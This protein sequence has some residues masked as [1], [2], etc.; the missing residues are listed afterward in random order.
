MKHALCTLCT[1]IIHTR[2]VIISHLQTRFGPQAKGKGGGKAHS[3]NPSVHIYPLHVQANILEKKK[4]KKKW[5]E[6][7]NIMMD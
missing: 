3:T 7:N 1:I 4:R 6:R 2:M 5:K